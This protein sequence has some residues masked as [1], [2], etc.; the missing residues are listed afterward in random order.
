MR[1]MRKRCWP[2]KNGTEQKEKALEQQQDQQQAEQLAVRQI[3]QNI[4][5]HGSL[6]QWK[7]IFYLEVAA[8]CQSNF[9]DSFD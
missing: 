4:A 2:T 3:F 1:K 6:I 7:L 8:A 9:G 5:N